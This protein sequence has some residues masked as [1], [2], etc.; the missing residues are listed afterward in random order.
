MTRMTLSLLLAR[1]KVLDRHGGRLGVLSCAYFMYMYVCMYVYM[2]VRLS[3]F[4]YA[5]MGSKYKYL[6][7][8]RQH[9]LA[10]WMSYPQA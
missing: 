2:Y 5:C 7:M 4:L 1:A 9:S 6:R 8:S 10:Q 3:L